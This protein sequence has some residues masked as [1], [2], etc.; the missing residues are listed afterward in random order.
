MRQIN[1]QP[2]SKTAKICFKLYNLEISNNEKIVFC[3]VIPAPS[4]QWTFVIE[5]GGKYLK[6]KNKKYD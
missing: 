2:I 6:I 1:K 4:Y 5:H 3:L